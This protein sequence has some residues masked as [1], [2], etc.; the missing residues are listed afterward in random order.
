MFT[1]KSV[2]GQHFSNIATTGYISTGSWIDLKDVTAPSNGLDG[3]GRL[4]KKTG[5]PGIYW[6]PDSAGAEVD[7]ATAGTIE[8][9]NVIIPSASG[10]IDRLNELLDYIT[11]PG[12]LSYPSFTDNLDGTIDVGAFDVILRVS[13]SATAQLVTASIGATIALAM[14]SNSVNYVYARYNSGSPDLTVTTTKSTINSNDS[15]IVMTVDRNGTTGLH[16]DDTAEE[17]ENIP[18]KLQERLLGTETVER[19]NAAG[20]LV[21]SN[22]GTRNLVMS[23][24]YLW[25]ALTKHPIAAVDTSATSVFHALYYNFLGAIWV[26]NDTET[27]W[28][29]NNYNPPGYDIPLSLTANRYVNNWFYLTTDGI[30]HQIMGQAQ[31]ASV[32]LCEAEGPPTSVPTYIFDSGVLIGRIIAKQGDNTPADVQITWNATFN[33]SVATDHNTLGNLTV[34]DVHTQYVYY[35]GRAVSQTING[36]SLTGGTLTLQS[37]SVDGTGVYV[38]GQNEHKFD[39]VLQGAVGLVTAPTYSF[40]TD[41][42]TGIYSSGA[43]KLDFAVGGVQNMHMN[44]TYNQ[45]L[46]PFYVPNGSSAAPSYAFNGN[47]DCGIYYSLDKL[48]FTINNSDVASIISTGFAVTGAISAT[49]TV[50]ATSTVTGSNVTTTSGD[51]KSFADVQVGNGAAIIKGGTQTI[52]DLGTTTPGTVLTGCVV[53]NRL[54]HVRLTAPNNDS[55]SFDIRQEVDAGAVYSVLVNNN[56]NCVV[57]EVTPDAVYD[58]TVTTYGTDYRLTLDT[59]LGGIKIAAMVSTATGDTVIKTVSYEF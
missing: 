34:G 57:T 24:G 30:V 55:C 29:N 50:T 46:L 15:F 41:T 53:T 27:Q 44:L 2:S 45:S 58:I 14:A 35:P 28:N 52:T 49:T 25:K 17:A 26:S 4:Y 3:A 10:T 39:K 11:S 20:G 12:V 9:K 38:I 19:D 16:I 56:C 33:S 22:T 7:L 8:T 48:N 21:I 43:D 36:S 51:V 40:T 23:T 31:Y 47:I 13:N 42:N 18:Q 1:T 59:A 5:D 54:I 37:N 32:T 6:K